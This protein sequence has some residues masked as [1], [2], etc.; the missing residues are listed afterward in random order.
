MMTGTAF[1]AICGS[2]HGTA[3]GQCPIYLVAIEAEARGRAAGEAL[4]SMERFVSAYRRLRGH[5]GNDAHG[6]FAEL[7]ELCGVVGREPKATP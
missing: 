2:I 1:C 6:I 4:A 7:D 3:L 5:F